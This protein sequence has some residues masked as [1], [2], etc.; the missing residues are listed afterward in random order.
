MPIICGIFGLG[1]EEPDPNERFGYCV[2]GFGMEKYC[3]PVLT[4]GDHCN[5]PE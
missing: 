3:C 1:C 2:L 5:A 4:V